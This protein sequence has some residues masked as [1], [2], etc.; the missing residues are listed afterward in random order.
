MQ[1]LGLVQPDQVIGGVAAPGKAPIRS[2]TIPMPPM[3]PRDARRT[4]KAY[5][6]LHLVGR[7][8]MH[9]YNN[10]DHAMMTAMLTVENIVAERRLYDTWCVNEDAE[11]RWPGLKA[12][13]PACPARARSRPTRPP[14]WLRCAP[15]PDASHPSRPRIAALPERVADR[16]DFSFGRK[17]LDGQ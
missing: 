6:S 10:Q 8:G 2:M 13:R 5:P 7:N 3:L 1:I 15:C 11:Y 16:I 14:R 9:G 12:P 4:G 17:A